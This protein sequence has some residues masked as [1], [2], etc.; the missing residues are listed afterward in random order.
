MRLNYIMYRFASCEPTWGNVEARQQQQRQEL[1]QQVG[2]LLYS[3]NDDG[4]NCRR[5]TH[6]EQSFGASTCV[7]W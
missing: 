6:G 4:Y 2:E 1:L 5:D 7:R 3:D